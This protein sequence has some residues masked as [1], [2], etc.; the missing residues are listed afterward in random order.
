MIHTRWHRVKE[1]VALGNV[2]IS[3]KEM[4]AER[5]EKFPKAFSKVGL[6]SGLELMEGAPKYYFESDLMKAMMD[7]NPQIIKSLDAMHQAGVDRLPFPYVVVEY[8]WGGPMLVCISET[9]LDPDCPFRC[10]AMTLMHLDRWNEDVLVLCPQTFYVSPLITLEDGSKGMR[11]KIRPAGWLLDTPE[12]LALCQLGSVDYWKPEIEPGLVATLLLLNTR[13]IEK[14]VVEA[15]VKLNKARARTNRPPIPKHTV[16]RVGHL[17][18]RSG[19]RVSYTPGGR[20]HQA[21]HW[22][23]GYTGARWITKKHEQ[24]DEALANDEGKHTIL[25]YVEPYLVNYDP[26]VGPEG[27]P[28]PEVVVKW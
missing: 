16:I 2:A 1:A 8:D 12:A 4:E 27:A 15:P 10:T 18:N 28:I 5:I 26:L 6:E 25:V 14:E 17:Y 13:G 24:F 19:A 23:P 21:M 3:T 22:R 11:W 7:H 20:G 9:K